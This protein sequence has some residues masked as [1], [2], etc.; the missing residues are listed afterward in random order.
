VAED[1]IRIGVS[2]CLL[3]RAVRYDG[4]HKR[5]DFL[6]NTFGRYVEWV[7]VCPEVELGLGTPRDTLRLERRADRIHLVTPRTGADHTGRMRRYAA[8]R[9]AELGELGLCGFVLKKD[10]P[11]CGMERVRVHAPGGVPARTGRGLF[12]EALLQRMP[13]L[14]VEE[15]GRLNDPRLRES[16]VVRVFAY[17]RLRRL[18]AGGFR[19]ADLIAF[20]TAHKLLVM[21]HSPKAYAELGR[22]VGEAKSQPRGTLRSRYEASLMSALSAIATPRRHANVLQ[23]ML[24]YLSRRI[25][26]AD[27]QE[28]LELIEDH[29]KGLSPL[30]VP[31]TLIRHHARRLDSGYLLG[32]VYLQLHPKELML[33]NH[34]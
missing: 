18:F 7:P 13:T 15:E 28:V 11:S 19:I 33:R 6:V 9:A 34:V 26:P 32:Q 14:P 24:G 29:R 27:R 23:H 30:A 20:H 2:A 31:L 21:A 8:R 4:G 22:L 25:E 12:A 3:G 16:F 17:R 10:S 1:V 5:D